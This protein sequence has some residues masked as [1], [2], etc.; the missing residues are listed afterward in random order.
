MGSQPLLHKNWSDLLHHPHL[1]I[2]F[3]TI[4]INKFETQFLTHRPLQNFSY[5]CLVLAFSS[6]LSQKNR[7]LSSCSEL[8]LPLV[9]S[10]YSL[11]FPLSVNCA[12][13]F[14]LHLASGPFSFAFKPAQFSVSQSLS[15]LPS[16]TNKFLKEQT[17][18]TFLSFHVPPTPYNVPSIFSYFI[19]MAHLGIKN[20]FLITKFSVLYPFFLLLCP[21]SAS[22]LLPTFMHS[23]SSKSLMLSSSFLLLPHPSCNQSNI[24]HPLQPGVYFPHSNY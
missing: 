8:T 23:L 5:V 9:N 4:R 17:E 22:E 16:C 7:H 19:D 14:N 3:Y 2:D 21:T 10:L 18:F 11:P 15:S 20:D 12:H 13:S 24:H 6:F 1:P